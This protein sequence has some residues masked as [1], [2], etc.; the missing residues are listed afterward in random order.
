MS[1][2][3][4]QAL[5]KFQCKPASTNFLFA[6]IV[7]ARRCKKLLFQTRFRMHFKLI[8]SCFCC[9][10][11]RPALKQLYVWIL[12]SML[13][14]CKDIADLLSLSINEK[15][16]KDDYKN[17]N[18]RHTFLYV[19]SFVL[20]ILISSM[21][22]PFISY[23][24]HQPYIM[25]IKKWAIKTDYLHELQE[26]L[27]WWNQ[28]PRHNHFSCFFWTLTTWSEI[29]LDSCVV[30][31]SSIMHYLSVMRLCNLSWIKYPFF[32]NIIK[33]WMIVKILL[34]PIQVLFVNI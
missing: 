11:N 21:T 3:P 8:S 20:F 14:W 7:A 30:F 13:P 18:H 16:K 27:F 2:L 22:R 26:F 28:I 33:L 17:E 19:V 5:Q 25:S 6:G 34:Y 10:R 23:C 24:F 29:S 15:E 4:N 1:S 32:L 9:W 12:F 31:I